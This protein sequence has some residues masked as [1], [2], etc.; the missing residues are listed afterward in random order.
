MWG[1]ARLSI[2]LIDYFGFASTGGSSSGGKGGGGG[3]GGKGAPGSVKYSADMVFGICEGPINSVFWCWSSKSNMPIADYNIVAEVGSLGQAPPSYPSG[4]TSHAVG[5]SN[6]AYAYAFPYQLG[7]SSSTPNITFEVYGPTDAPFA[8]HN[9]G[10]RGVATQSTM[11]DASPAFV[12]EDFLTNS[13]YGIGFPAAF[14]GDLSSWN[15]YCLASTLVVSPVIVDA[16]EGRSFI[17][18]LM[19][20]TNSEVVWSGGKL[21]VV[22]YSD[23]SVSNYGYTWTFPSAPLYSLGD[24]DFKSPQGANP[25]AQSQAVL[26]GPVQMNRKRPSDMMNWITVEYLDRNNDYNTSTVDVRDDASIVS[27]GLHKMSLQQ[28]HIFCMSGP[29]TVAA[30]NLLARQQVK[31]TFTFTVGPEYIMLDP[32]DIIAISDS[33]LGLVEQWVRITEITENQDATLTMTAEEIVG[34][35]GGIPEFAEVASQASITNYNETPGSTDAF[36]IVEPT[37]PLSQALELW[38]FAG[39]N[40][41]W[42]GGYVWASTDGSTYRLIG[43]IEGSSRIGTLKTA[44]TSVAAAAVGPTFDTTNTPSVDMSPTDTQLLSG[45]LTDAIAGNTLLSID[46]ELLAYTTATLVSG[47]EYTLTTELVRGMY[48]TS[49]GAHAIGASVVRVTQNSYAAMSYTADKVGTTVYFKITQYNQYGGGEQT[50]DSVSAI[51]YVIKGTALSAAPSDV[52][53][54]STTYIDG[55][56]NLSWTEVSDWRP[57]MYEIRVGSGWETAQTLATLAHPPFPVPGAGT[58]WVGV[59]AK[60]SQQTL[61]YDTTPQSLAISSATLGTYEFANYNEA[62]SGWTGTVGGSCTV[63]GGYVQTNDSGSG[64]TSGTYEIVST[65][66]PTLGYVG[67]M[68]LSLSWTGVGQIEGSNFLALTDVLHTSDVLGAAATANTSIYPMV[69]LSQ[70]GT[71]WGSWQKFV[72]GVVTAY[73]ADVMMEIITNDPKTQAILETLTVSA[74]T[75]GREDHYMA[76]AVAAGGTTITFKPDGAASSA[77]FNGGP[78]GATDPHVQVTVVGGAAGDTIVLSALSKTSVTVQITNAGAGVARTCNIVVTG[79]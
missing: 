15:N 34:S 79:Y 8:Q 27:D 29:A 3:G 24:D 63:T 48:G 9:S 57:I 22:P 65:H 56:T 14:L 19:T 49:P 23:N 43:Q 70:D 32:M 11:M 44:I 28:M 54:L 67:Q 33:R 45:T 13:Q 1:Q 16:R 74:Y 40:T 10:Y 66:R 51:S 17:Q 6:L 53:N 30:Q 64:Q 61:L 42:G 62:S 52:T 4:W 5:Y 39:G 12:L 25:N 77:G 35:S 69:R 47:Q 38:V 21:T 72:P 36:V 55:V 26:I 50:L 71:T 68:R 58:Y 46:S 73:A 75:D 7:S 20:A 41:N 76:V 78:N 59:I 2:N 37:Y 31:N 18:D 60:S